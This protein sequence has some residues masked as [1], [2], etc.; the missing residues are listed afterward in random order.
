M[1]GHYCTLR[2]RYAGSDFI[3]AGVFDLTACCCPGQ[4]LRG[5]KCRGSQVFGGVSEVG[6]QQGVPVGWGGAAIDLR[7]G[8]APLVQASHEFP[9]YPFVQFVFQAGVLD[10]GVDVRVVVD[11]DHEDAALGLFDVDT[12]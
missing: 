12:V 7:S 11:L 3:I 1:A 8:A 6:L 2:Q 5:K 10:A 9:Q 4:T